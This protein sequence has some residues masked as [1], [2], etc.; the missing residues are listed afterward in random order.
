MQI[1][2]SYISF[3]KTRRFAY[4]RS[5]AVKSGIDPKKVFDMA[6]EALNQ[7]FGGMEQGIKYKTEH[8]FEVAVWEGMRIGIRRSVGICLSYF[9]AADLV[10]LLYAN[11]P[12]ANNKLYQLKPGIIDPGVYLFEAC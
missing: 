4:C 10:P 12:K 1:K 3:S 9:T 5:L 6:I 7:A 2:L 8:L 11:R